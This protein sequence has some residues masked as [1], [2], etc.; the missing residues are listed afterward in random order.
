MP[1]EDNEFRHVSVGTSTEVS[2]TSVVL[3]DDRPL[4]DQDLLEHME[5]RP[6]IRGDC[7][8]GDGPCPFA[9][10]VYHLASDEV[11]GTAKLA[12]GFIPINRN[13]ALHFVDNNPGGATLEAV[14]E[15]FL[16]TRERVRQIERTAL[17]KLKNTGVY[18][19]LS[20]HLASQDRKL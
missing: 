2:R 1:E 7:P 18:A 12:P 15:E 6:S 19:D 3:D 8:S 16:L 20:E 10:C 14:G 4:T 17:A 5:A 11:R 9:G 13:C